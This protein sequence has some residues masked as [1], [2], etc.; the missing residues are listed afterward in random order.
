[1][2]AVVACDHLSCADRSSGGL[3]WKDQYRQASSSCS[4]ESGGGCSTSAVMTARD[5]GVG[6]GD[7]AG[8]GGGARG[9]TG[10]P[11]ATALLPTEVAAG[12]AAVLQPCALQ[13]QRS[14][15]SATSV[16]SPCGS[17]FESQEARLQGILAEPYQTV[18]ADASPTASDFVLEE[19]S[20]SPDRRRRSF[21]GGP[22]DDNMMIRNLDTGEVRDLLVIAE[23]GSESAGTFL[24]QGNYEKVAASPSGSVAWE[25]WRREQWRWNESLWNAAETGTVARLMELLSPPEKVSQGRGEGCSRGGSDFGSVAAPP[26]AVGSM[27][28]AASQCGGGSFVASSRRGRPCSHFNSGVSLGG[29]SST[30]SPGGKEPEE[31]WLPGCG[32]AS[33]ASSTCE[34]ASDLGEPTV[35]IMRIPPLVDSRSLY[36]RTAL[37][38]AASKGHVG[39]VEFLLEKGADC[40]ATTDSGFTGF[41]LA[42]QFGHLDVA[43]ALQK[44][45]CKISS[46]TL[47]G[48][49]PHHLAAAQGFTVLVA[50]LLEHS[51]GDDEALEIRN[52][53]G[54]RP[55]DVS[56]DIST[57]KLFRQR[58]PRDDV[59][60]SPPENTR[61]RRL[62]GRDEDSYA[63]RSAFM[64]SVLLRNSRADVVKRLL[65]GA[66]KNSAPAAAAAD[67]PTCQQDTPNSS[68][69]SSSRPRILS[70]SP[71]SRFSRRRSRG[72]PASQQSSQPDCALQSS[73]SRW[74]S[75]PRR[76]SFMN[77]RPDVVEAVG[78][79]SFTM[80]SLLGKGSFGEVYQVVHR[81]T[82]QTYAMKVLRKSKIFGRN[83]IRYAMTERNLLSYIRHPFIVRLHYA[84]QTSTCLVLVLHYCPGGNLA[85]LIQG[86]VDNRLQ[87]PLAQLYTAEILM[88]IEHLHERQVIFRDLKA[89]N[90]VLDEDCHAM[91]T[92]FG[93]SKEGVGGQRG[94]ASFCG[95]IAYLAP[96]ILA[97]AGHGPAVDVYGLGVLLFES[98]VGQPPYYDR[99]RETLFRNIAGAQLRIPACVSPQAASLI[100]R[101]INRD[102]SQRLGATNTSEV[103]LHPF[104]ADLDF[105]AVLAREVPVP[106]SMAGRFHGHNG[107]AGGHC[108][109]GKAAS[110]FEGRLEA[111]VRRSLATQASDVP[112]WEF[113]TPPSSPA[114]CGSSESSSKARM[115]SRQVS[116]RASPALPQAA[117]QPAAR[118]S[119]MDQSASQA[120]SKS[121][122]AASPTSSKKAPV[123][124]C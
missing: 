85:T 13:R 44:A 5:S 77:I 47:E 4:T 29:A 78:P 57:L 80:K 74:A 96:E 27:A 108:N 30:T 90:V 48:D 11:Y 120:S 19:S 81:P 31:H 41:H 40:E 124:F 102:P 83:L 66:G 119:K 62:A 82:G 50:F 115:L 1:M 79:D 32:F 114:P 111:Q 92:D 122:G 15:T 20:W 43:R 65:W 36:G 64:G 49:L 118:R 23:S 51:S 109:P 54:Q 39:C 58:T 28:G 86:S 59:C 2:T 61:Q 45:G 89:E 97:R 112:N 53:Y 21:D 55:A 68:S 34:R 42:C 18:F 71:S 17:H 94:T 67:S 9:V 91:L 7:E 16:V 10:P 60:L 70:R 22:S 25:S 12:G 35:T 110:P 103:R 37:H 6:S 107:G 104:F 14:A 100:R 121:R 98:L 106:S 84:F 93:L 26:L 69:S 87:E 116:A 123:L 52:R 33:L 72:P 63:G 95:S 76:S 88:A 24:S 46:Q 73:L 105:D 3:A 99:N 113:A 75:S 38:I 56:L 101:L 117:P 8:G